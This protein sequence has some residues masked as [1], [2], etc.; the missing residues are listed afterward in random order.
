MDRGRDDARIALP[1][2]IDTRTVTLLLQRMGGGDNSAAEDLYGLLYQDLRRRADRILGSGSGHTLQPTAVVHEAWLKLAGGEI[3]WED[4]SHFLGVA[5]KAMRMVLT[6]YVRARTTQK[7]GG[8]HHKQ[9]LD[10]ALIP[11]EERAVDLLG[12]DEA[13]SRLSDM[14]PIL[15]QIVEMRFFGGLTIEDTARALHTSESTVERGWRAARAWL[16][17][18]LDEG[19]SA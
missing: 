16:R 6:D 9:I 18:E 11:F 2:D 3:T 10:E 4:R 13:L 5:S 8:D 19:E 12:L 7:R 1:P 14:D 17:A 15:G